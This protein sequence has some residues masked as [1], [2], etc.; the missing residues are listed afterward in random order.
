MRSLSV[1]GAKSAVVDPASS[2][3]CL[4]QDMVAP[5]SSPGPVLVACNVNEAAD[6]QL[7]IHHEP[8]LSPLSVYNQRPTKTRR[9]HGL[10]NLCDGV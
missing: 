2:R 5:S 6:V 9:D 10:H 1:S 7:K 4:D 8:N 3:K